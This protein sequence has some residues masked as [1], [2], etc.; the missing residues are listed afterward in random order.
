VG[1]SLLGLVSFASPSIAQE[2]DVLRAEDEKLL[3]SLFSTFLLDPRGAERVQITPLEPTLLERFTKKRREGWLVR[4]DAGDRVYFTNGESI[5]APSKELIDKVDFV[6]RCRILYQGVPDPQ[7]RNRLAGLWFGMEPSAS[8]RKWGEE[9]D[10]VLAAWLYR[11]GKRDLAARVLRFVSPNREE[12]LADLRQSLTRSIFNRMFECFGEYQDVAALALG[13]Q[14]LGRFAAETVEYEQ[15]RP[16]VQDLLRRKL[17]GTLGKKGERQ[18]PKDYTNWD[19]KRKLAFLLKG[20]DEITY[21]R[22]GYGQ[23][24]P[25]VAAFLE[26][27][28]NAVPALID[29]LVKDE[30]MTRRV[31]GPSKWD[32]AA[33]VVPVRAVLLSTL[34][35]ILRVRYLNPRGDEKTN[36]WE[37]SA[38][39]K[40]AAEVAGEYW[41]E[42]GHLTYEER[43][44][45]VLTDVQTTLEAQR[46]AAENLAGKLDPDHKDY[47]PNPTLRKFKEPTVAQ[48][49]LYTMDRELSRYDALPK[50]KRGTRWYLEYPYFDALRR[51]G[52]RRITPELAG[53]AEKD[54]SASMRARWAYVCYSLG[55]S[56]PIR[57]FANE[58]AVGKVDLPLEEES[59]QWD[60]KLIIEHMG[61]VDE[62]AVDVALQ[63]L[64]EKKHPLHA[65]TIKGL[66]ES[67]IV[68]DSGWSYLGHPAGVSLLREIL[69]DKTP[70]RI[71]LEFDGKQ[72]HYRTPGASGSTIV[73]PDIL[74]DPKKRRTT[75]ELRKCD[76]AGKKLM[77]LVAGLSEYHPLLL[78]ADE[79]LAA[80]RTTLDLY[81]GRFRRLSPSE[82]KI[83]NNL[84][85]VPDLHPLGRPA[86]AEDVRAGK[87]IFHLGGKGRLAELKLPAQAT[88][89]KG[90]NE[91]EPRRGLIVQAEVGSDGETM[92]GVIERNAIRSVPAGELA[93]V[94]PLTEVTPNQKY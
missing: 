63:R 70:A 7:P 9:P 81:G 43:L 2:K 82:K 37:S 27:G 42:F 1:L 20:L 4:G 71:S 15:A 76:V 33:R 55:E 16:L 26:L 51:L 83:L 56:R 89:E 73:F 3:E 93:S 67:L 10:L 14:L 6:A 40:V 21:F 31:V 79:R 49:V 66:L 47:K 28:E 48:A 29:A 35:Q 13:E 11:L 54:P 45:R 19:A 44:M 90:A 62:P 30:R 23:V 88:W 50:E 65:A 84:Y 25:H 74:R 41:K 39:L 52:D 68:Y 53:R 92:Y 58:F 22:L 8:S 86:T 12:E 80:V 60:L 61:M 59:A 75:A 72:L 87:A 91:K 36:T 5:P 17:E 78:D 34:Q 69:D 64:V 85:F 94:T 32:P 18:L 57:H 77:Y 46:E 24:E 38:E